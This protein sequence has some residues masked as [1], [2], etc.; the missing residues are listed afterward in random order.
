MKIFKKKPKDTSISWKD[1]QTASIERQKFWKNSDAI[2]LAFIGLEI[3]EEAGEVQG[4]LKKIIRH[5]K[6]IAG[7]KKSLAELQQNL[8]NEIGDLVINIARLANSLDI[9]VDECIRTAFN[10]KSIELN[11]EVL[12]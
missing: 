1:L 6:N 9:D 10:N 8:N 4:A 12:L 5:N 11:I 7:N 2:D 3:G